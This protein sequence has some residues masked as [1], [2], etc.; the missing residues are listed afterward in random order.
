MQTVLFFISSTRHTCS[1]RLEGICRYARTQ[2]WYVQVVERAFHKVDV[3]RQLEFWRPVGIIAE[4]GSGAEEL[5]PAAFGDI[6]AVYFDADMSKRGR[7]YYV[8]LDCRSVG[9]IACEHLM[10]L[11]MPNYAYASFRLPMFWDS[12]RRDTFVQGLADAGRKCHLFNPGCEQRPHVRQKELAEWIRNLPRPCGIFAANDYVGEEIIN[13]CNRLD[14][15]VPDEIAVLG[16]DNDESVCENVSPTLSSLVPDFEDGGY[17]AARLLAQAIADPKSKPVSYLYPVQ[18][19]VTR[20]S[21]RRIICNRSRI[22]D[23]VEMIRKMAC[24]GITSADV[25]DFIGEPR[26]TAE[27]HFREVTGRSIHEEIDEVRFAKVFELLKNPRQSLD[28]LPDLC[29]FKTGVALRK[30]FSLRTG[31]SMRD[32]RKTARG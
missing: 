27:M 9:R 2:G 17:Q 26:R 8:G 25:V 7:G 32:W 14:I 16:V 15:S 23:A 19:V 5:T 3:A 24:S 29:G 6:P 28:S 13:I 11:D 1:N 12:E 22:A 20:Q 18:R 21:T 10:S 31:M 30:A 4:C